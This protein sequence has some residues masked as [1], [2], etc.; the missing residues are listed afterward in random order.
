M[1]TAFYSFN[2]SNVRF[3]SFEDAETAHRARTRD[4]RAGKF[5]AGGHPVL[6]PGPIRLHVGDRI[7]DLTEYGR[8]VD[9]QRTELSVSINR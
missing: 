9:S 3:G 8:T 5:D 6:F 4:A 2:G 7:F 1:T